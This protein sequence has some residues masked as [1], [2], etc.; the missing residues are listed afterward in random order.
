SLAVR[1]AALEAAGIIELNSYLVGPD[2][3][4]GQLIRLLPGYEP[5]EL[6]IYAVFPQ[7]RYLAPKVQVFIDAMLVRMTPEPVWDA[8]LKRET[9]GGR[10]APAARSA[11]CGSARVPASDASITIGRAPARRGASGLRAS[12]TAA[13][14]PA[15]PEHRAQSRQC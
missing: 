1:E 14:D 8:F 11:P 13:P 9:S 7:R 12:R 3:L 15:A 6:S 4:S 2:I 10:V 5:R